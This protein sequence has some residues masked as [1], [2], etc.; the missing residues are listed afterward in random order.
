MTSASHGAWVWYELM[1]G[2]PAT[3][4]AFYCDVI[5]WQA[6]DAGHPQ[7]AYTL[8]GR[9]G[10]DICGMLR[11]PAEV[12]AA[13]VKPHWAGYVAT[14]DVDGTSAEIARKGGKVHRAP[15][16]IT[17]IGRFAVVADRQG[18]TFVLFKPARGAR[19]DVASGNGDIGWHELIAEDP[20]DAFAFY[21]ELFGWT[22]AQ[23]IDMGPMGP[24]QIFAH[25]GV[26]VGGMMR[27]P[28][29]MPAA[30]WR[31]YIRVDGIEAAIARLDKAGG[32]IVDGPHE[33][34]GD[35]WVVHAADPQGARFALV[36]K[37][38]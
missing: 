24:Y 20:D 36:S 8:F 33:V 31:Y 21:A 29:D 7:M 9:D 4:S 28:A 5:G 22:K 10:R 3:A 30:H 18:A 14:D 15:D 34:P 6:R 25:D 1:T 35:D 2:D 16:D 37:V 32:T 19:P 12:H 11:M 23:T 27:K 38:R 26:A 17:D 13:G